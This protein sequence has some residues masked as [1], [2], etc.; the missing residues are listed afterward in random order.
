MIT[1]WILWPLLVLLLLV[2]LLTSVV[3]L[4]VFTEKGTRWTV[5]Q[6]Q[7]FVPGELTYETL[8]GTF[9]HGVEVRTL[10]YYNEQMAI[11]LK[12]GVIRFDWKQLWRSRVHLSQLKLNEFTLA[13]LPTEPEEKPTSEPFHPDDLPSLWL[14]FTARIANA[15][16]EH[17]RFIQAGNLVEVEQIHLAA[18]TGLRRS[19]VQELRV[20][21]AEQQASLKGT[22]G[23]Q[24][25][26]DIQANLTWESQL[27]EAVAALFATQAPAQGQLTISGPLAHLTAEH[28]LTAPIAMRTEAKASL[29]DIPMA[30]FV[31]N[32]WEP[33]ALHLDNK[34]LP[35]VPVDSGI[36]RLTGDVDSYDVVA[37][38]SSR[39]QWQGNP[40]PHLG[41]SLIATGNSEALH[42]EQLRLGLGNNQSA[43]EAAGNVQW[44]PQ[45][46]WDLVLN[47]ERLN[48]QLLYPALDGELNALLSSH[49]EITDAGPQANVLLQQL[50]GHWLEHDFKG[51]GEA[52]IAPEGHLKANFTLAV[53]DNRLRLQG[54]TAAQ[55][56]WHLNLAMNALEELWP[57]AQ[58]NLTG[59]VKLTGRTSHPALNATV[60]GQALG[61]D[62][63]T[64][65]GLTLKAQSRGEVQNPQLTLQVQGHGL[66]QAGSALLDDFQ[67]Q[68]NGTPK[69]HQAQWA[70]NLAEH[71]HKA[72]LQGRLDDQQA[73]QGTLAEFT[74]TG[75]VS[76]AWQLANA[77]PLN[78]SAT[79]AGLGDFCLTHSPQGQLCA[80]GKWH[81]QGNTQAE[82]SIATLPLS[83]LDALLPD[84]AA[85]LHGEINAQGQFSQN[86]AGVAQ[87]KAEF[88]ISPGHISLDS[89]VEDEPYEVEWRGL[90]A[91]AELNDDTFSSQLRFDITEGAGID[92]ELKGSLTG[93]IE[94]HY[95][96]HMEE[97]AWLEILSPNIRELKGTIA[98]DLRIGGTLKDFTLE[99]DV[100]AR[101]V[102]LMVP[103]A[104]LEL[105]RGHLNATAKKGEP[106]RILG[107]LHSGDGALTLTGEVPTTGDFPRPITGR[108]HGENF[109]AVHIPDAVVD[110]NPNIAMELVGTHLTLTGEVLVPVAHITPKQ[111][112]VQAVRVSAD[113]YII[114]EEAQQRSLFTTD[115]KLNIVLG[116]EVTVDGFGLTA[117][118]AG[119]VQVQERTNRSTR[120][121]GSISIEEGRFRAYGQDLRVERG[122]LIFQGPPNNPGLDIVAYRLVPA[123][124]VKA[125]L[126]LG[127]TLMNPRSRVFSEPDMDETE[128]MA[129]LLTGKPLE[130]GDD[131]DAAAIIQAIAIYGIEKGEFITNRVSD[132]LGI[133]V[134]VDT[135]G[136][137]EETALVLGKQLSSRLY[138]RYSIGLFEALNTVMLRYTVSRYVNL[139]TRSNSQEQAID[140]I[141][142]RER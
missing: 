26:F 73:W 32:T 96:M 3:S 18:T 34:D 23:M 91:Q 79:Q 48:P 45:L 86:A 43:L 87:G 129:F 8:N 51:Q 81:A 123:Y 27:P 49:G 114:S 57:T 56:D 52:Q 1:R 40:L 46:T 6:V 102:A 11:H 127:G 37:T 118:F 19:R 84:N 7:G 10:R 9:W 109:R 134:G 60:Q 135:E 90:T 14:P 126:M 62:A 17:F 139:E 59:D 101:D 38:A 125:G 88:T 93:P 112:P 33:F 99:G 71:Q 30:F 29:F 13:L 121:N 12:E 132:T 63:L 78:A 110:I 74:L 22:I 107:H 83:V 100:K 128:A 92:G 106:I 95:W 41:F 70:L 31:E 97:L 61:V 28:N 42:V 58:G 133:D 76:G 65:E 20:K 50:E 111:L 47:A 131:A 66:T 104:G 16:V 75:P 64:L 39:M 94:G 36:M 53:G 117:R 77:V 24:Q 138:L 136:E 2:L 72:K 85:H 44:L 141:Y 103:Q 116:D 120:L 68:L 4:L 89:G 137:F 119:K 98:A 25:P 140:L 5:E 80:T 130:G 35:T 69:Q 82:F 21:T 54:A 115:V 113:E 55:H 105:N 124:N 108:I 67:L 142:R 122:N 15:Q